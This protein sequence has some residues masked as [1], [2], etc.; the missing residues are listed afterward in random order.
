MTTR[1]APIP[2]ANCA[3]SEVGIRY[4]LAGVLVVSLTAEGAALAIARHLAVSVDAQ[5]ALGAVRS[6]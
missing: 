6:C 3:G 5:A 1:T 2:D 4:L